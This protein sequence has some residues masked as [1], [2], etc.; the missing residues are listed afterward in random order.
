M[1]GSAVQVQ[2]LK[3]VPRRIAIAI[4]LVFAY[5]LVWGG[6]AVVAAK[7]DQA[8][9]DAWSMNDETMA[10]AT[11]TQSLI[12]AQCSDKRAPALQWHIDRLKGVDRIERA[13]NANPFIWVVWG[14]IHKV[15]QDT[16]SV[17]KNTLDNIVYIDQATTDFLTYAH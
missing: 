13:F 15:R 11:G 14:S 5:V 4:L 9:A 17:Q 10:A 2:F 7:T 6:S 16:S 12:K 8:Y 1:E 3:R